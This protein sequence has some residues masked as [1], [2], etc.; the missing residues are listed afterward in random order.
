[1]HQQR[2]DQLIQEDKLE[3]LSGQLLE[4]SLTELVVGETLGDGERES[5]AQS[6]STSEDGGEGES[7]IKVAG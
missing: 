2:D 4:K 6:V 3:G 1:M 5:F 7:L